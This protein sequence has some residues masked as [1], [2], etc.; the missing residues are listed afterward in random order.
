MII[1]CII[2]YAILSNVAKNIMTGK[3]QFFEESKGE[4][5]KA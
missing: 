4:Y 2:M 1:L 3:L 5:S